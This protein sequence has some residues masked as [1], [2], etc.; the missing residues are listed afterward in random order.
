[1]GFFQVRLW[2]LKELLVSFFMS[3]I[4]YK[5]IFPSFAWRIIKEQW[6]TLYLLFHLSQKRHLYNFQDI[7][8]TS[9]QFIAFFPLKIIR[10]TI[11]ALFPSESSIILTFLLSLFTFFASSFAWYL[12]YDRSNPRDTRAATANATCC[13][14]PGKYPLIQAW[15]LLS[16]RTRTKNTIRFWNSQWYL[17]VFLSVTY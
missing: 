5:Y 6:N 14:L 12:A 15:R 3:I 10:S 2:N 4:S 7:F 16:R 11:T 8:F 13:P 9:F 17:M 1:M